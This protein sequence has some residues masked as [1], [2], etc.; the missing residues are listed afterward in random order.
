MYLWRKLADPHWL[1]AHENPLQ[2]RSRGRLVIISRPGRKRLQLEI[3]CTSRNLGREL[4]EEFGGRAEKWPR[5]WLKRFADLHKSE[6][7][8]IGKRLLISTTAPSPA[9]RRT[10]GVGR[11]PQLPNVTR[12]PTRGPSSS[13]ARLRTTRSRRFNA[14]QPL[15][16]VIPASAAFG[17]GEHATT[18]MSLRLLERLSCKWEKGWSLADLGT[19]SGILALAAKRFGAGRVTGIDLDPRAISIAK[20]NARLNKIDNVDFQLGDVRRWKPGAG[21]DVIAANLY[22]EL[23][24]SVASKLNRSNWL[25]LSGVL[26]RQEDELLRVLQKDNMEIASVKRRGKWIALMACKRQVSNTK[27][28]KLNHF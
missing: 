27:R 22:N 23:L 9:K 26:R 18:A 28:P 16:L 8:K 24:I 11:S 5:D 21:W 25:I 19:G 7:L 13:S 2:A 10:H 17:T 12:R 14:R 15:V 4:I 1:S 3:V 20:A 6:P